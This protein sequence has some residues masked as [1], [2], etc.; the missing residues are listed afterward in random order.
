[1]PCGFEFRGFFLGG[2]GFSRMWVLGA[3]GFGFHELVSG[4]QLGV[5][6][7]GSLPPPPPSLPLGFRV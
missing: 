1:M 7:L 2:V 5:K 3:R 4:N 6:G